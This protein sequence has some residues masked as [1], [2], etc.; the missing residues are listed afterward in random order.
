MACG[1]S[2]AAVLGMA[3]AMAPSPRP[4]LI[5]P[6]LP[7]SPSLSHTNQPRRSFL[8]QGLL[9]LIGSFAL[10]GLTR[11]SAHAFSLGISGPKDWLREQKK[12]TADF[13]IAPI[14]ASRNR[15][16]T[17]LSLC[18]TAYLED[19]LEAD[20]LVNVAARD[21]IRPEAGS[22]AAFQA[23]T[24]VEVCTFRLILKNAASLLDDS[25]PMKSNANE[26]LTN[27]INSF[28]SLKGILSRSSVGNM[29]RDGVLDAFKQTN[30]ALDTFERGVRDCLG[31]P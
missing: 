15:L 11:D 27:L 9:A 10:D 28:T 24:G 25:D 1:L 19:L 12:K 18:E 6:P 4:P 13:L 23:K 8:S 30:I 29:D 26:A 5:L 3:T 16:R 21:C 2:T 22:L 7:S 17:A 31:I 20:K 14:S